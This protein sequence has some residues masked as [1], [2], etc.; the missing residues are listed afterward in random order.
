MTNAPFP[1]L[2]GEHRAKPVPPKPHG[3]VADIDTALEQQIFHLSQGQRITDIHHHR[4]ADHLG[5]P[6]EITAGIFHPRRL[7]NDTPRLKPICS[8]NALKPVNA[9]FIDCDL[10]VSLKGCLFSQHYFV[11]PFQTFSYLKNGIWSIV[12]CN[13]SHRE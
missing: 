6:V 11:F 2:R 7:W 5:R 8:D 9:F 13:F 10:G 3:F 1:D 12:S 4:E